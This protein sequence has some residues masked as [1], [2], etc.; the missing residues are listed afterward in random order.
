MQYYVS[1]PDGWSAKK[2]WPVVVIIESANKEFRGNLDKFI[3]ARGAMPFI[4]VAPMVTTNGGAR[5]REAPEYKYS[6]A[7]W[8]KIETQGPC[9]FDRTGILAVVAEVQKK[10]AGEEKFFLAGWEAGAHT[11][12]PMIFQYPE[13]LAAATANSPNYQG[14]CMDGREYSASPD[15]AKVPVRVLGAAGDEFWKPGKPFYT[16]TAEAMAKLKE[17]G[18]INVSDL[19]VP[20]NEHG[21]LAKETLALFDQLWNGSQKNLKK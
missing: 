19:A 8:T 4:L 18:F 2:K 7:D 1:L 9:E 3:A 10:Y 5:Y 16:Q 11:V 14:R 21:P 12:W 15:R 13:K 6:E 17:K 20:G